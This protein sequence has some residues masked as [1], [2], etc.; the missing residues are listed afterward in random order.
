MPADSKVSRTF[1]TLHRLR[2][3]ISW[4]PYLGQLV[5]TQHPSA[6]WI[7]T[8]TGWVEHQPPIVD[9]PTLTRN[10]INAR[11]PEETP[12]PDKPQIGDVYRAVN[13]DLVTIIAFDAT[14][15]PLAEWH[16][17]ASQDGIFRFVYPGSWVKTW[18]KEAWEEPAPLTMFFGV[19]A[20]GR[21]DYRACASPGIIGERAREENWKSG[22][23]CEAVVLCDVIPRLDT[24]KRVER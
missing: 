23:R 22:R 4:R 14:K 19:C 16:E 10:M 1:D 13:G 21:L 9:W 11:T 6:V 8:P 5:R 17:T 24:L 7:Y 15:A 18:P 2:N 3:D 20:D 12:M